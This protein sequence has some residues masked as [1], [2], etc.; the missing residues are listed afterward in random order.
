MFSPRLHVLPAGVFAG[1]RRDH[2]SKPSSSSRCSPP[3]DTTRTP[4]LHVDGACYDHTMARASVQIGSDQSNACTANDHCMT[5]LQEH[6]NRPCITNICMPIASIYV[7]RHLFS[8]VLI[9]FCCLFC[10]YRRGQRA[11][12]PAGSILLGGDLIPAS[13][14]FVAVVSRVS[15]VVHMVAEFCGVSGCLRAL[16]S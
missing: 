15:I 4:G 2:W 6:A 1:Y 5:G 3:I 8:T 10:M 11:H 14:A 13:A 16:E 7:Y 9:N 12:R